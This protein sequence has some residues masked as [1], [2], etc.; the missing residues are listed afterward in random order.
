MLIIFIRSIIIYLALLVNMRL[1]GKRQLGELQPFE[2]AIT[3]L[4]A[5]LA[6][7]PMQDTAIPILHGLIPIFAIF[8]V[9]LFISM[10]NFK[11]T[12]LRKIIDGKPSVIIDDNGI[13]YKE[14][15][16]LNM[17]VNDL[18]EGL[19]QQGYFSLSD[20]HIAIV[21]TNG[22]LSVMPKFN[23]A[24]VTNLDMKIEGENPDLPFS[25]VL[26]GNLMK[27]TLTKFEK[28][29]VE[30]VKTELKKH[31]LNIKEVYLFSVRQNGEYYLQPYKQKAIIGRLDL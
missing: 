14:M 17:H 19:R 7:I 9:H 30:G 15:K 21:E 18:M 20:V 28:I 16:S 8:I 11:S 24:P 2:F 10:L 6:T 5:D 27:E 29:D 31:Q 1:M 26:E 22:A 25:L 4:I 23:S 13:D 3:L 12:T